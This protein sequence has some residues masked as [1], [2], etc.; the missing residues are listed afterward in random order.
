MSG[1]QASATQETVSYE[2][3]RRAL[4]RRPRAL[5]PAECHGHLC[6]WLAVAARPN[7]GAWIGAAAPASTEG[8]DEPGEQLLRRLYRLTEEALQDPT[9]RFYP[10]LPPERAPLPERAAALGQWCHGFL[11]GLG[12]GGLRRDQPLPEP[13][14]EA[15]RDFSEI[16][17]LGHQGSGERDEQAFTEV[18][19]YVRMA[20]LLVYEELR[21]LR[22]GR[23]VEAGEGER[24][25]TA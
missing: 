23:P 4:A 22:E 6:G 8:E 11:E 10:L 16:S 20:A 18:L 12:H 24:P 13:V 9:L 15:L 17:R 1:T 19:E 25:S 14:Q 2:E 5:E 21:P 7:P 3:L